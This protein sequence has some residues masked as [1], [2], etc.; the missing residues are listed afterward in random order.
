MFQ[1]R[2]YSLAS[3]YYSNEI[4]GPFQTL[5]KKSNA[6]IVSWIEKNE[7]RVLAAIEKNNNAFNED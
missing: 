3:I 7:T 1:N 5:S 2:S 4:Y 6:D